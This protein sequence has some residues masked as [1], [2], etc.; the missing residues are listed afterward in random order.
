M[1]KEFYCI[2]NDGKRRDA[3]LHEPILDNPEADLFCRKQSFKQAVARGTPREIAKQMYG[4]D[5]DC[6]W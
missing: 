1:S 5:A 6:E 3:D 2:D 4:A